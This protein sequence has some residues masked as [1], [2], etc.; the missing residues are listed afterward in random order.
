M[1][2]TILTDEQIAGLLEDLTLEEA[3]G[4]RTALKTALHEYSTGTQ[5]A[6][7]GDDVQQ[8]PR[9]TISPG[10]GS[11]RP[12]TVF[13]PSWSHDG[14]GMKVLTLAPPG[15][16]DGDV[17]GDGEP[18][19]RPTGALSLFSPAG[20]LLGVLHASTLTAF[21]TALASSCLLLRRDTVQNVLVFGSGMQAYWHV[22]LALLFRG[23]TIRHVNIICRR[24]S[25]SSQLMLKRFYSTPAYRKEREGWAET[26]FSVLTPAYNEYSRLLVKNL[27]SA[28]V[29]FCCTPSTEPLFDASVL[30]SHEGR[31]KGRLIVAV[32]S[33]MRSMHELPS[34]LLRQATRTE[35]PHHHYHRHAVEGG[36]VVVDTLDGALK[37]AGEI[38][39]AGLT[40][41]QVVEL[42]ELVMLSRVNLKEEEYGSSSAAASTST[43]SVP[44]LEFE[45]LDLQSMQI[46][47][48]SSAMSTVFGQ[49]SSKSSGRAASPSPKSEGR[50]SRRSL[51]L[52]RRSSSQASVDTR[53]QKDD[54]LARWMQRGNVVYKSVGLGLMDL[55]VGLHLIDFARSKGV[56]SHIGGF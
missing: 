15:D 3:E 38:I 47:A 27:R 8:P 49:D 39:D 51:Q 24:L 37:E 5:T 30:T 26:Q 52:H 21:R 9:T 33:F 29:I 23:S 42:G 54:H 34:E 35:R 14:V 53:K 55:S 56:G 1:S 4:F 32:G 44:S 17:D 46:S 43:L 40:P 2:L 6:G 16:G 20:R 22:R 10:G 25:Q 28:D 19:M 7:R 36:V 31:R 11:T 13:V 41:R 50:S 48:S 18:A 12:S 45:R